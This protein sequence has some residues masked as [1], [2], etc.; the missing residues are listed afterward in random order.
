[1]QKLI[2][3]L[4][5]LAGNPTFSQEATNSSGS[6]TQT[7]PQAQENNKIT[8][9]MTYRCENTLTK[10]NT[11]TIIFTFLS[12][13]MEEGY[14]SNFTANSENNSFSFTANTADAIHSIHVFFIRFL[15]MNDGISL[16]IES[17]DPSLEA[18]PNT[19]ILASMDKN[20]VFLPP[21]FIHLLDAANIPFL[22]FPADEYTSSNS[23]FLISVERINFN[24]FL[25]SVDKT[26]LEIFLRDCYRKIETQLIPSLSTTSTPKTNLNQ[27]ET[28]ATTTLGFRYTI[29]NDELA[30]NFYLLLEDYIKP[31]ILND[32]SSVN[33]LSDLRCI[34]G[35]VTVLV[36]IKDASKIGDLILYLQS[37]SPVDNTGISAYIIKN[38]EATYVV[39]PTNTSK[40]VTIP[41][42]FNLENFNIE[43]TFKTKEKYAKWLKK[44]FPHY[45]PEYKEGLKKFLKQKEKR[46]NIEKNIKNIKQ[47]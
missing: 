46:N 7:S 34:D 27:E 24:N 15:P 5:L 2:F 17:S 11:K 43:K 18:A 38:E 4:S 39:L 6:T 44:T 14:I 32:S 22:S 21:L 9:T 47:L 8:A 1:M 35:T 12:I 28:V 40:K 45:A 37:L 42:F 13:L 23:R 25:E 41:S 33:S 20:N 36:G 30:F 26:T 19:H 29:P 31:I 3:L 10:K 16:K